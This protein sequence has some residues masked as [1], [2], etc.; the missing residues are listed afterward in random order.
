[1]KSSFSI[2]QLF[3]DLV[4]QTHHNSCKLPPVHLWHPK[5]TGD[6]DLRIDREGRWFHESV[7]IKRPSIINLFSSL[8]K[9]EDGQYFLVTP[10]EKWQIQVD[11]A[12]FFIIDT[13]RTTRQGV[14]AISVTTNTGEKVLLGRDNPLIIDCKHPKEPLLPL[15]HIRNK[16]NALVSRAVYYQLVDWGCEQSATE[17]KN[18]LT[19]ESLDCQFSLGELPE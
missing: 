5:K 9:A 4:E 1:V 13:N 18:Q 12:P 11:I 16:L 14:Q 2:E 17:G 10:H 7:E 15:V 8:L 6:M 19:L 3:A